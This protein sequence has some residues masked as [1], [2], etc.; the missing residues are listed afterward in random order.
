MPACL[1]TQRSIHPHAPSAVSS[2][3]L[4][5]RYIDVPGAVAGYTTTD[6]AEWSAR[7]HEGAIFRLDVEAKE[8]ALQSQRFP[9]R[10]MLGAI[11][12]AGVDF[13]EGIV[14]LCICLLAIALWAYRGVQSRR[15]KRRKGEELRE[16][17]AKLAKEMSFRRRSVRAANISGGRK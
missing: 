9:M 5:D 8:Q 2:V 16:G 3:S 14:G 13:G 15:V 10:D 11:V 12:L 7:R 6:L 4:K 1:L 17:G